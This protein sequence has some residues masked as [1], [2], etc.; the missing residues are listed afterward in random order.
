MHH[1]QVSGIHA[2]RLERVVRSCLSDLD[3]EHPATLID[4]V[5]RDPPTLLEW[6]LARLLRLPDGE[7]GRAVADMDV[8][9]ACA[10]LPPWNVHAAG[11]KKELDE[12]AELLPPE[13]RAEAGRRAPNPA[14]PP[15]LYRP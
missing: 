6:E 10:A 2:E 14:Q 13:Q 15:P 8:L 1:L 3:S 4:F 7:R 9:L 11:A 5:I 12:I